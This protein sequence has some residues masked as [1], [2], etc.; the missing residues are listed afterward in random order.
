[1]TVTLT[2]NPLQAVVMTYSHAK[3]QG[4]RSVSLEDRVETDGWMNGRRRLHYQS[5]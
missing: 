5:R 4:Q 2:F 1:M 3:V